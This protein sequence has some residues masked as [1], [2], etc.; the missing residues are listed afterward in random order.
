MMYIT[1]VVFELFIAFLFQQRER[2][3]YLNY[4]LMNSFEVKR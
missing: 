4:L 2:K 3:A 1:L